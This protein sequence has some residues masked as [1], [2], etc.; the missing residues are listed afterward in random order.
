MITPFLEKLILTGKAQ[1]KTQ[2]AYSQKNLIPVKKDHFIV[3]H[4]FSYFPFLPSDMAEPDPNSLNRF[5]VV[6]MKIF[7]D[8]GYSNFVI[9]N[10]ISKG[11]GFNGTT[12][13]LLPVWNCGSPYQEDVYLVHETDVSVIFSKTL[14]APLSGLSAVA[15]A[16]M[17]AKRVPSDYGSD[18]F[19]GSFPVAQQKNVGINTEVRPLGKYTPPSAIALFSN[20]DLEFPINAGTIF[21]DADIQKGTNTY[22]LCIFQ[23]VEINGRPTDLS[24][25]N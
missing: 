22:P 19:A 12:G 23:Y 16:P 8:K 15:P 5:L 21:S 1:V 2:I 9:R 10:E 7:S 14:Q 18:G 3:I 13:E 6:Q 25:T 24:V 4:H 11:I 17:V 20:E